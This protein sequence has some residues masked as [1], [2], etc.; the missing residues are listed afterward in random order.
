MARSPIVSSALQIT[1]E[2]LNHQ[3]FLELNSPAAAYG[4]FKQEMQSLKPD[5]AP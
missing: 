5:Y 1:I 2:N 4:H 3:P